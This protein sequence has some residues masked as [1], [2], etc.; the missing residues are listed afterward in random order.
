[1]KRI[2]TTTIIG[3]SLLLGACSRTAN[4]SQT[5]AVSQESRALEAEK[6]DEAMTESKTSS[7]HTNKRSPAS[8]HSTFVVQVGAFHEKEN[9]VKLFKT[10]HEQG[11]PVVLR[12][13]THSKNGELYL[14]HL[15]PMS[16]KSEAVKWSEQ[17]K[18][19]S[20]LSSQLII[21]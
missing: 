19:K 7:K 5:T 16:D 8:V 4:E 2:T 6:M 14:V 20:S 21:R 18:S 3:F 10:L 11:Y 15:E 9:A 1:M 17:L 13:I 12:P